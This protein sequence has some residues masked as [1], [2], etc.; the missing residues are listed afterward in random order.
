MDALTFVKEKRRMCESFAECCKCP[1]GYGCNVCEPEKLVAVVEKWHEEN[2]IVTNRDKFLE[3]FGIKISSESL[4][5]TLYKKW[6]DKEY[7]KPEE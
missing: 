4:N 1:V 2:P 3:V 5:M 6:L 7:K